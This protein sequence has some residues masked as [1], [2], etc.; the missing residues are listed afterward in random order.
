MNIFKKIICIKSNLLL[1]LF[2][3]ISQGVFSQRR[4]IKTVAGDCENGEALVIYRNGDRYDGF[5]KDSLYHGEGYLKKKDKE[6]YEGEF[7]QG[8][9]DG[10]G[11]LLLPNKDEYEGF[12][13]EGVYHGEGK[14]WGKNGRT[15]TGNFVMGKMEGKGTIILEN[16]DK[17]IGT[18]KNDS[19]DGFGEYYSQGFLTTGLFK[20]G[21]IL[22]GRILNL[23]TY[24]VV[25][26]HKGKPINEKDTPQIK[27]D[28]ITVI[29]ILPRK[30]K[31]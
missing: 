6:I 17:Y 3:L 19:I 13:K 1:F 5:F 22:N 2:C 28:S 26:I 25:L 16:G 9:Y 24:E 11:Y 27:N 10:Y 30:Q 4:D 23:D 12:F 29:E 8:K 18:F 31:K 20:K 15:Y 14:L 7:A 21:K